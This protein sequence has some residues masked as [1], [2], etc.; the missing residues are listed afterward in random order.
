MSN[1][2][3]HMPWRSILVGMLLAVLVGA[4][5]A[6]LR[7]DAEDVSTTATFG[8]VQLFNSQNKPMVPPPGATIAG[9]QVPL[10]A[11][12]Q[13]L[14]VLAISGGGSDGAFGAGALKGW[15]E[16]GQRPVFNIVTGVSTGALIA[17][18]AF[19]GSS[20]DHE[21]ER[22]YTK[23]S[24]EHIYAEKG[25]IGLF[26]ESLYD[27]APFRA[28]VEKVVT[29]RLLDAVAAEHNQGRRLYVA[30]TDL[31]S[32][33]VVVWDMGGI[34]ASNHPS[35]VETYR[36]VLVAS[37]AFPGFFKPVYVRHADQSGRARMHVDGGVKAPVLLRS[38][39]MEGPHKKKT[40]YMLIN[41][42]LSLKTDSA[43]PVSPT[44]LGISRRSISE[45]MR[46][47]TYKTLYQA[48]VTTRRSR[49][50]FRILHVPDAT[51]DI[52]DPLRFRPDE[53]RKLFEVG[54][55]FGANPS[56]WRE[57]PPRLEALERVEAP[58]VMNGVKTA[59][60]SRVSAPEPA[61]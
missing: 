36:D 57:E 18:F 19:L 25:L 28:M 26:Q 33:L 23:V 4:C 50:Q 11:Q 53:M 55:T 52:D 45:L 1:Q 44:V 40:L 42:K 14:N 22:F 37:A 59:S 2:H 27:T 60:K 6:A 15:T 30:T 24:A 12:T 32:G 20:W 61:R 39:M 31:D 17:T 8:S 51:K 49:G 38:F 41:G 56:N 10:A 16:S 29:N 3:G 48:Y 7:P 21:I 9:E 13:D 5:S 34:A 46:G 47:L 58:V 54:R 43:E 35:R